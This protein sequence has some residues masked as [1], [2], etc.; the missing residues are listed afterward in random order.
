MLS[1]AGADPKFLGYGLSDL[2]RTAS[3]SFPGSGRDAYAPTRR[4]E[5][6]IM[7]W[8]PRLSAPCRS[9][10][11]A[12]HEGLPHAGLPLPSDTLA[13]VGPPLHGR[14]GARHPTVD[15]TRS[16]PAQRRRY[17]RR[18]HTTHG[19]LHAAT[20]WR[21]RHRLPDLL[22]RTASASF[23]ELLKSAEPSPF[24]PLAGNSNRGPFTTNQRTTHTAIGCPLVR[25]HER[26]CE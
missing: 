17:P 2:R 12:Q 24:L 9:S 21:A 23:P 22:R 26:R 4:T 1:P 16:E 8:T 13:G 15:Q 10:A 7:G 11:P 20:I 19:C 25:L 14:H 3:V 6:G 5:A 18:L